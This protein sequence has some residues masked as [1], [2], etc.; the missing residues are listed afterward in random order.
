MGGD[1]GLQTCPRVC[2]HLPLP[3]QWLI[4][5]IK[6]EGTP[7]PPQGPGTREAALRQAAWGRAEGPLCFLGPE[8]GAP[9]E[10][11]SNGVLGGAPGAWALGGEAI[12]S[13][14]RPPQ[15]WAGRQ[16]LQGG[17][18]PRVLGQGLSGRPAGLERNSVCP[19]I[20]ANKRTHESPATK[21]NLHRPLGEHR[22][23]SGRPQPLPEADSTHRHPTA[24]PEP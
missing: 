22:S 14:A 12:P 24:L 20:Q 13:P 21:P 18:E 6:G 15:A 7:W 3:N 1:L 4:R 2:G 10:G 23:P 9:G 17:A 8:E 19:V 5:A 11:T 16:E